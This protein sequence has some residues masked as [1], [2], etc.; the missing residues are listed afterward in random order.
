M[1][2]AFVVLSRPPID[3]T[4]CDRDSPLL[5]LFNIPFFVGASR[6][7]VDSACS[8]GRWASGEAFVCHPS[9]YTSTRRAAN[10]IRANFPPSPQKNITYDRFFDVRLTFVTPFYFAWDGIDLFR[11]Y[12]LFGELVGSFLFSFSD[13]PFI[14]HTPHP[15]PFPLF[16]SRSCACGLSLALLSACNIDDVDWGC[17]GIA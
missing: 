9:F 13:H 16:F 11:L 5:S 15:P 3:S 12:I 4:F 8:R 2:F 1:T 17:S 14:V 7:I 10:F 6:D